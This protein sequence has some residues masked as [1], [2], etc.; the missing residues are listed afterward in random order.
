[1]TDD[2]IEAARATREAFIEDLANLERGTYDDFRVF[3]LK[4]FSSGQAYR[5]VNTLIG[6]AEMGKILLPEITGF[7][8]YFKELA[9]NEIRVKADSFSFE[10]IKIGFMR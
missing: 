5:D 7:M 6:Y 4:Y 1:M 10:E 9:Y 8:T 3:I 2:K